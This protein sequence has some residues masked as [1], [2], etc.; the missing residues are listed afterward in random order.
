M[1]Y[2]LYVLRM[3][4]HWYPVISR[5]DSLGLLCRET[6]CPE[7]HMG[8]RRKGLIYPFLHCIF[9]SVLHKPVGNKEVAGASSPHPMVDV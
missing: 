6:M 4:L 8:Y 3:G 5:H 2:G 7:I 1:Y 9:C